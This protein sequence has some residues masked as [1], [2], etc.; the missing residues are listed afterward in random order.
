MLHRF[1]DG[2]PLEPGAVGIIVAFD[3]IFL[4]ASWL[5]FEIVL[6]P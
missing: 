3:V 5:V 4:T 2:L 6:E 1:R